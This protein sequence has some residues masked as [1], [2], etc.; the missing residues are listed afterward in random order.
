[1]TCNGIEIV[2][3]CH[4]IQISLGG[5]EVPEFEAIP[6]VGMLV[7]L[8]L[9]LRGLP[10]IKYD[11]LKLVASYYLKIPSIALKNLVLILGDIEFIRID[12]EGD[13]IKSILPTVP[14]FD[15]IYSGIGEYV[16]IKKNFNEPE[17]VAITILQKLSDSPIYKSSLYELGAESKLITRNLQIGDEGG[18]IVARKARGKDILINPT[19]FSENA[20]IYADLVAKAGAKQVQRLLKLIK[21]CQGWPLSLIEANKEINGEKVTDEEIQ[22]LKRLAQDGAVKPPAVKTSHAGINYFMFPPTPGI[23]KLSHSKK[24]VYE[25][26]MA[27]TASVR[28]GQLLPKEYAIKWPVALL[29]ALRRN[30]YLRANTEAL[31]QYRKLTVMRV[32]YLQDVGFGFYRFYLYD[33]QENY[34]AVDIAIS[35]L[36]NSSI[37]GL[38]IDEDARIALIKDEEY[39]ESIVSSQKLRDI[40]TISLSEEQKEEIDNILLGGVSK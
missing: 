2:S 15:D 17:I 37:Q 13:T 10:M 11:T 20:D 26:A 32:G 19:Y 23:A 7:R 1:M 40:E 30:G 33:T 6:E 31:E 25:R 21:Q 16:D 18:Y 34:E 29:S 4:D 35:M 9:H 24:E 36:S 8:A 39:I 22:L 12:S 27:I 28:Q 3:K 38:E 5:K 14:Y